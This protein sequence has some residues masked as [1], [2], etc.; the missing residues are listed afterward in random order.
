MFIRLNKNNS[1]N[2]IFTGSEGRGLLENVIFKVEH[3]A[4]GEVVEF[5]KENISEHPERYDEILLSE[6]DV[7]ALQCGDFL[8]EIRANDGEGGIDPDI[9][10]E[11]GRGRV[12]ES[13]VDEVVIRERIVEEKIY[14]RL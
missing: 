11:I 4:T 2:V 10:L 5:E 13:F 12:L 14:Q 7:D 8:Y 9:L 3:L 6:D 1:A